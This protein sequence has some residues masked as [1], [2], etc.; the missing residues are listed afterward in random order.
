MRSRVSRTSFS[1]ASVQANQLPIRHLK[2]VLITIEFQVNKVVFLTIFKKP[3]TALEGI[4]A[5]SVSA[6]VKETTD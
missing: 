6:L 4:I 2:T 5:V 3:D 1:L